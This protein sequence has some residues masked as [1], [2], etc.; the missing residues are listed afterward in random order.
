MNDSQSK[1]FEPLASIGR[2]RFNGRT[3]ELLILLEFQALDGGLARTGSD[4]SHEGGYR[5][6]CRRSFR[7]GSQLDGR[8][9][10][11]FLDEDHPPLSGGKKATSSTGDTC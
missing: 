4:K 8:I 9:E 1:K 10:R 5:P 11:R 3:G 7:H 6:G 2:D